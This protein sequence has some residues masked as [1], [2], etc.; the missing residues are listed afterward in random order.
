MVAT[1]PVNRVLQHVDALLLGLLATVAVIGLVTLFSATGADSGAVL[2]QGMRLGAGALL[3][4][5]LA[6][7]HPA[8]L[9][10]WSVVLYG[11]SVLLLV[12]VELVG[13]GRGA[14]RWLD[15]GVV[16]FQPSELAKLAVPLYVGWFLCDR[17]LPPRLLSVG[18]ALLII[19]I[20]VLLVERQ[21]DLG[22]AA[23]IAFAGLTVLFMSGLSWQLIGSAV[24]MA[25]VAAPLLWMSMMD[26]QRQRVLTFLDPSADPLGAGYHIIQSTI[27]VG[28]GGVFGKGWM[29]GTQSHLDFVPERHTDF[30]F[31]VYCEEFGLT[32]VILLNL[33]YAAIIARGLYIAVHAQ[34][35]FGR[36]VAA[37]LACT[38]F[39]YVFVNM[40]MVVGQLPVVGVPLPLISYGGTSLVTLLA[41]F[42]ILMSVHSH[43]RL[44]SGP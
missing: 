13:E 40:G 17:A 9:G 27:A 34:E 30:I 31:A 29:R 21:P 7:V 26:Y 12:A 6:Q 1:S 43:R 44:L 3:M 10:R 2:R 41:G 16:R 39:V 14:H 32:G 15:L 8:T 28:S 24:A 35:T 11:L 19:A 38:F 22:T 33:I 20:P 18:G 37:S 36:I 4:V 23:L 42:G 25:M 5:L